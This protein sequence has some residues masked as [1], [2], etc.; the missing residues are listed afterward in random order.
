MGL[1]NKITFDKERL[2]E[3]VIKYDRFRTIF[4]L[5]IKSPREIVIEVYNARAQ[6]DIVIGRPF[7]RDSKEGRLE[8][9][10]GDKIKGYV[11][12]YF[13]THREDN[14]Y[15]MYKG[16]FVSSGEVYLKDLDGFINMEDIKSIVI[17]NGEKIGQLELYP[18]RL[19]NDGDSSHL[20]QQLNNKEFIDFIIDIIKK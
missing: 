13:C 20:T 9:D 18:W 6:N 19:M 10:N 7:Y 14:D 5:L 2:A 11:S 3:E 1:F 16:G 12:E 15:D 17:V 8:Y 4:D